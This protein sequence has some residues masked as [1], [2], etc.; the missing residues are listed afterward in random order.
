MSVKLLGQELADANLEVK[1]R[2]LSHPGKS[3]PSVYN[4]FVVESDT[5]DKNASCALTGSINWT[6]S[7]LCTQLNKVLIVQDPDIAG[8]YLDQWGKLVAAGNS[9]PASRKEKNSE[10]T[11]HNNVSLYFAATNGEAEFKP[12]SI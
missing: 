6:T 8:R 11:I 12:V 7:G 9:M 10:P 1:H 5:S 2:D 3:S 4:K